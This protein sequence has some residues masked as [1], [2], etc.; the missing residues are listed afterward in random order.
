[1]T[2]ELEASLGRAVDVWD[3]GA[4]E[5][6]GAERAASELAKRVMEAKNA[7]AGRGAL[8]AARAAAGHAAPR[9]T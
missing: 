6:F 7:R 9:R 8:Q 4:A 3:D 2:E 1:M 5:H